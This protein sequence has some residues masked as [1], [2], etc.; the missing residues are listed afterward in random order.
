MDETNNE[1]KTW[2]WKKMF[3]VLAILSVVM[4]SAFLSAKDFV[5]WYG[6]LVYGDPSM[7]PQEMNE[8]PEQGDSLRRDLY[9]LEVECQELQERLEALEHGE[10]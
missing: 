8:Q 10:E 7:T 1:K 6:G 5:S 4:L 2:F 9:R 3:I